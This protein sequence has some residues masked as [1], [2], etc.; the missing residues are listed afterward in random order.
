[1]A[2]HS[3]RLN[4]ARAAE[5]AW[6]AE[7]GAKVR[8]ALDDCRTGVI[9]WRAVLHLIEKLW[10]TRNKTRKGHQAIYGITKSMRSRSRRQ[11]NE[12]VVAD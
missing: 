10:P 11:L 7:K 12:I 6:E 8:A 3:R 4:H 2:V 5:E 9:S 1:M